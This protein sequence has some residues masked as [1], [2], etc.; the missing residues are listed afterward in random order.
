[1]NANHPCFCG[2]NS[3]F[4]SC[5]QPYIN[6]DKHVQTAEQLMRSRFSAYA[7]DNAQYIFETYATVSQV[8]QSVKEIGDWSK[9]CVWIALNIYP[10]AKSVNKTS[11][12]FVEF[13]AFYVTNNT[14][15]ELRE[16]SRFILE[17]C[18]TT[19]IMQTPTE[20]SAE[21]VD[22][23]NNII[24]QWRYI[25]GDIIAHNELAKIKRNDMCPCN[26]YPT[27]WQKNKNKKFKRCCGSTY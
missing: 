2:S 22:M 3:S 26:H 14:L 16:K 12:Q 5:C 23:T 8:E 13:S 20:N 24:K 4:S 9:S 10:L 25:D 19:S 1:M 11:E 17:E 15:C 6:K 18:K 27:A 7:I 21:K